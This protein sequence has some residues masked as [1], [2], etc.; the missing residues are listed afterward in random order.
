[1]I[2]IALEQLKSTII[3]FLTGLTELNITSEDFVEINPLVKH[4]GTIALTDNTLGITLVNVE[5]ERVVK[6]QK[7]FSIES[8][9]QVSRLNPEIKL[10]LFVLIS[11]NFSD[12]D[13][14]L[15][16]L[17]AVIRCF[18]SNNVFTHENTPEMDST[19]EKLIVELFTLN[20]EQQNHLWGALGA[21]YVPSVLYRVRLITVQES[22][23]KAEESPITSFRV[24]D[25]GEGE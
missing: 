14:G 12:Y 13:K 2:D 16:Y 1:M 11:A 23:T 18:Q 15:Q 10:N 4:D 20:F 6:S 3:R 9:G 17:S 5:E 24:S 19:L 22:L 7:A 8:N 21:K 25:P